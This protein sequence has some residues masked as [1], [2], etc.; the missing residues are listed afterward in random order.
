MGHQSSEPI[1]ADESQEKRNG[2]LHDKGGAPSDNQ[3]PSGRSHGA[4]VSMLREGN[5]SDTHPSSVHP[6]GSDEGNMAGN[7]EM[8]DGNAWWRSL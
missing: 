2:E 7:D 6:G 4:F 5:S 8:C 3:P 1:F